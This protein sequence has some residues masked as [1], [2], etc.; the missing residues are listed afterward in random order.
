MNRSRYIVRT[1]YK[2]SLEVEVLRYFE[3]MENQ[4]GFEDSDR[5]WDKYHV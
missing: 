2:L 5:A 4:D 3:H 1:N